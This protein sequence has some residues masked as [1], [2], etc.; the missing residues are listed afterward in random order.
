MESKKP[1]RYILRYILTLKRK[2]WT[3]ELLMKNYSPNALN[4][5][6]QTLLHF[7]SRDIFMLDH[8][9]RLKQGHFL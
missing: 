7:E 5:Q 6:N 8:L 2:D 9:K 4:S 1:A 3:Y